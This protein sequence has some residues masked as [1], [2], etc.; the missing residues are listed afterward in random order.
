MHEMLTQ[1]EEVLASGPG[2]GGEAR[3]KRLEMLVC[4]LLRRNQELRLEI[5][6]LH[7]GNQ[8]AVS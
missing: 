2:S 6:H 5:A 1:T 8:A 4:E 3:N 7:D